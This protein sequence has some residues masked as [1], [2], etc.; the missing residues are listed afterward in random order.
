MNVHEVR[1][2]KLRVVYVQLNCTWALRAC[3]IRPG[4][5]PAQSTKAAQEYSLY[6]LEKAIYSIDKSRGMDQLVFLVDF[7][8]FSITQVPSMDLSKEVVG[9]LND[10]YTDI[11]AKAYMLDAP[12][13]FDAVWKFAKM[14]LHPQ[15]A[16]K[17]EFI[18]TSNKKELARLMELIPAEFLEENLGGTCKAIYDHEK[19]WKAE[20][21]YHEDIAR[22]TRQEVARMK[23]DEKLQARLI[24]EPPSFEQDIQNT[25]S[26]SIE[27]STES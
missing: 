10:H 1:R 18:Q 25:G 21:K 16:S 3:F 6:T 4:R 12:S 20:T 5:E 14:L 24:S 2:E 9:I 13:Y 8:G 26:D 15:T 19:Y 27:K 22:Y 23:A 11:L 7:T 17:V